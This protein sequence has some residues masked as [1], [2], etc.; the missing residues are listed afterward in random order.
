MYLVNSLII[1]SFTFQYRYEALHIISISITALHCLLKIEI[2]CFHFQGTLQYEILPVGVA[3]AFFALD[4]NNGKV[5]MYDQEALF[6][7]RGTR[8]EVSYCKFTS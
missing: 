2:F 8:Y 7:D 4:R 1:F 6:I 3:P 5:S